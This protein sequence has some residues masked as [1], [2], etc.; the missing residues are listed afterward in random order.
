MPNDCSTEIMRYD[1]MAQQLKVVLAVVKLCSPRA[2]SVE[3]L[4]QRE[5]VK[6]ACQSSLIFM[7]VR[8]GVIIDKI[9]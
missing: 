6:L 4:P 9:L 7:L 3:V 5:E 8:S 1:H 2:Q